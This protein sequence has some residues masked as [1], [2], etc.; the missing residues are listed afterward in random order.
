MKSLDITAFERRKDAES[1]EPEQ[2]DFRYLL[3]QTDHSKQPPTQSGAWPISEPHQ[4]SSYHQPIPDQARDEDMSIN[5]SQDYDHE[6]Q[7]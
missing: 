4:T 1:V 5:G 7:F 3:R 6:T 2:H